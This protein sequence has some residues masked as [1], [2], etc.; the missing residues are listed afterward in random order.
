MFVYVGV[1]GCV[2]VWVCGCVGVFA[3]FRCICV[4]PPAGS[5]YTGVVM[6]EVQKG[7]GLGEGS[8]GV[9][10]VTVPRELRGRS[11]IAVFLSEVPVKGT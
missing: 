2:G 7:T 9:I 8:G 11:E 3:R 4:S 10:S 6:F 5:Q 1:C